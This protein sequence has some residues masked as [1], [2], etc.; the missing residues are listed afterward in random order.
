MNPIPIGKIPFKR[1]PI[2]RQADYRLEERGCHLKDERDQ[3]DLEEGQRKP[4]LEHRI[5]RRRQRLHHVVEHMGTAQGEDDP[6]RSR[7]GASPRFGARIG[8]CRNCGHVIDPGAARPS[9]ALKHGPPQRP[10]LKRR[11]SL[12]SLRRPA[13]NSRKATAA[14]ATSHKTVTLGATRKR[15]SAERRRFGTV[16]RAYL[17]ARTIVICRP[18]IDGSASTLAIGAVSAL[19]RWRSLKPMS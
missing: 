3:A 13:V 15:K 4:L 2:E 9:G 6:D 7:F 1:P 8:V 14:D 18:S 19:T 5:E 16:R 17:G 12:L 11:P 10:W